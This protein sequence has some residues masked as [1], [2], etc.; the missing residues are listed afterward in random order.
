MVIA[1]YVDEMNFRGIAN[2]TY[3]Y[4]SLSKKYLKNNSIIF[5]E[6]NS[7]SLLFRIFIDYIF[8]KGY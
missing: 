1:F 7:D 8:K 5:Y 4:A 6:Y 3:N 2:S